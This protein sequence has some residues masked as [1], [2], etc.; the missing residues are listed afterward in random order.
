MEEKTKNEKSNFP[1]EKL[2]KH[3][4]SQMKIQLNTHSDK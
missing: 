3:S 1:V 4:L 2:G